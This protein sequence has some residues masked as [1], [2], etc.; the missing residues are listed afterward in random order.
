MWKILVPVDGSD[1][2]ARAVQHVI[3]LR[4]LVTPLDVHLLYV[5][6]PPAPADEDTP[7]P[8]LAAAAV[9]QAMS[10][11]KAMLDA[12]AIPY[13]STVASGFVGSTI[14]AYATGHGCDVIVMGTRGMGSTGQLLGSIARQV[15][16]FADV[17]VTLVKSPRRV[18]VPV[19]AGTDDRDT[20]SQ[21]A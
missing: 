18:V 11:A 15:I 13:A 1:G 3:Q 9:R 12:A 10:P 7:D 6:I 2:S 16:Q 14:A 19:M 5:Q 4:T 21:A 17:P 20:G 8:A